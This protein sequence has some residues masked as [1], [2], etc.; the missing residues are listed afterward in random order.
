MEVT[1]AHLQVKSGGGIESITL[2]D[3]LDDV[4]GHGLK[5]VVGGKT[6]YA[7]YTNDLNNAN[8]SKLRFSSGGSTYGV[9]KIA[10][11]ELLVLTNAKYRMREIYPDAYNTM[12]YVPNVLDT[13]Q[14]T[15]TENMYDG[16]AALKEIPKMDT[17]KIISFHECFSGCTSLPAIFP[18]VIDLAGVPP[19]DYGEYLYNAFKGS[20]VEHVSVRNV[21]KSYANNP[22]ALASIMGNSNMTVHIV[23]SNIPYYPEHIDPTREIKILKDG[24]TMATLLPDTYQTITEVPFDIN[25]SAMTS[26]QSLFALCGALQT[27]P[28]IYGLDKIKPV[29]TTGMYWGCKALQ[30][31]PYIDTSKTTDMRLMYAACEA[32][33]TIPT[34][35]MGSTTDISNMYDGCLALTNVQPVYD[36]PLAVD[37]NGMF[38]GCRSLTGA[39]PQ[40]KGD[41]LRDTGNM[42]CDCIGLTSAPEINLGKAVNISGMYGNCAQITDI[43]WVVDLRSMAQGSYRFRVAAFGGSGVKKI[44]VKVGDN[45]DTSLIAPAKYGN[46]N[47]I[48]DYVPNRPD[49]IWVTIADDAA[50]TGT[51]T[52]PAGVTDIPNNA[53]KDVKADTVVYGDTKTLGAYAYAG[54]STTGKP[55]NYPLAGLQRL[56]VL[57]SHCYDGTQVYSGVRGR[58]TY[59]LELTNVRQIDDYGL[60]GAEMRLYC[61]DLTT[62]AV[63]EYAGISLPN[64][65]SIGNYA[66]PSLTYTPDGWIKSGSNSLSILIGNTVEKIAPNAFAGVKGNSKIKPYIYINRPYDSIPGAPWGAAGVTMRWTDTTKTY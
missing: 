2:Y 48:V 13:S 57:G 21:A 20:H 49:G 64:V 1:N 31:V 62:P 36:A 46:A 32:L 53:F 37:A 5:V 7:C 55:L 15:T 14:L 26:L 65:V 3:S 16:C 19:V 60:Q 29:K 66:L 9:S 42:Y 12:T 45:V 11:R 35:D 40:V 23:N 28:K 22:S 39:A 4:Y 38:R 51:I 47:L 59:T 56:E 8:M 25:V 17:S 27:L 63:D 41:I 24:D 43:P 50:K 18:W 33:T 54:C 34:A 61:T 6:L 44:R 52:I 58:S 10:A 30:A